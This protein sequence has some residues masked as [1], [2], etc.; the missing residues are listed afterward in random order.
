MWKWVMNCSSSLMWL[1]AFEQE[2]DWNT[3]FMFKE[4]PFLRKFD[5]HTSGDMRMCVCGLCKSLESAWDVNT[6]ISR[7]NP[8]AWKIM[9]ITGLRSRKKKERKVVRWYNKLQGIKTGC[10]FSSLNLMKADIWL[11]DQLNFDLP[12]MGFDLG[13][14][15]PPSDFCDLRHFFLLIRS[16]VLDNIQVC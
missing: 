15:V 2:C 7:K 14:R 12:D 4:P 13:N 1:R 9:I 6:S 10:C 16:N 8:Y 3:L 5:A 11:A